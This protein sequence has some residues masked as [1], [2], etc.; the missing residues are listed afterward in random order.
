MFKII[1]AQGISVRSRRISTLIAWLV[2]SLPG[3]SIPSLAQEGTPSGLGLEPVN[4]LGQNQPPTESKPANEP[5][6]STP[7]NT[8][9]TPGNNQLPPGILNPSGNQVNPNLTPSPSLNQ[10]QPSAPGVQSPLNNQPSAPTITPNGPP[11][12]TAP[13]VQSPL[14]NRPSAPANSSGTTP[15]I[16]PPLTPLKSPGVEPGLPK[17][18]QQ[19]PS[20]TPEETEYTV[21]AGDI[22]KVDVFLVPEYSGQY[23]VLVDGSISFPLVGKTVVEGMT[24]TK[25]SE[26]LSEKYSK[27]LKKP[28]VTV[29]LLSPRPLKIS[30]SGEINKPGTYTINLQP[31]QKFPSVTDLIQLSGGLTTSANVRQVQI[32]R[33]LDGQETFTKVNL[34]ELIQQGNIGQDIT[35]RD[36]DVVFIPTAETI[37]PIETRTLADASFGIRLD[38]PV[39]IA[40]VGEVYRPGSYELNAKQETEQLNSVLP[41]LTEGIKEAG[42][43]KPTA[44]LRKVELRRMTRSGEEKIIAVDLWDLLKTGDVNEDLILQDGDTIIVPLATAIKPDEADDLA[45]AS[46]SPASIRINVIGEV[47]KPGPVEVPSDTPLNQGI[48][49]AGGFNDTRAE[50]GTVQLLRLNPDGTVS[51]REIEIDLNKGIDDQNNP[52]LRNND[53]IVVDRNGLTTFTDGLGSVLEPFRNIFP[54]AGFF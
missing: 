28:I 34:W 10:I 5:S 53:V 11:T 37:D 32:T 49:A 29:G 42:G 46:F 19:A 43:I 44:D 52:S 18:V 15:T 16:A 35:L 47:K 2:L 36:G 9:K 7:S 8:P 24:L 4:P 45:T 38:Q 31:G 33:K 22:L 30:M 20:K 6:L 14:N 23:Q 27:Y 25:M 21:G 12:L 3:I 26:V 50:Q 17:N 51:Q 48:L 39:N 1:V 54:F 13:G 41:R 40:V